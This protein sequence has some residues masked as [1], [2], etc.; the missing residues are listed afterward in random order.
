MPLR[1]RCGSTPGSPT[2]RW[3][4]ITTAPSA[5]AS[6]VR[7]RAGHGERRSRLG[8]RPCSDRA[9]G[10]ASPPDAL[11]GGAVRRSSARSGP[12]PAVSEGEA[13]LLPGLQGQVAG[14]FD[15]PLVER[16]GRLPGELG[17]QPSYPLSFRARRYLIYLALHGYTTL[18]YPFTLA[19]G[20]LRVVGT[21]AALG[22]DMGVDALVEEAVSLGFDRESARQAMTWTVAR[23]ALRTGVLHAD[24]IT[25]DHINEALEA[26]RLF[27]ERDDLRFFY[28]S[29]Q[30]Y[31]DN[32]QKL[33]VTHLHQLH[34]VLFHRGRV[35]TRPRKK[36][37][38][39]KPPLALPPRMQA[40]AQKWLAARRLT[41]AP[42]T[43]EQLE[44]AVRNFGDWLAEHYPG[45]V[46]WTE[47]T[48]DH[49]LEWIE[50]L[51]GTPSKATGKP[52]GVISRKQRISGL[53][54]LFRET[55]AWEYDD[56][57]GYALISVGDAP[58]APQR[59]PRFI[60]DHELDQ[61]MP[62]IDEITC[63]FQRAA[64][65]AV[66]WSGARRDEIRRL[67][68]D[69][70]DRYPDGTPRLRLPARK[71]YKERTV[72]LHQ[73]AADALQKVIDLRKQGR[74]RPFTD[75]RTG[76]QIRY[77]F[78]RHGKLIS[79]TYLFEDPLQKASKA[80]G[81]VGPG[82]WHGKQR[83]TV[84]AH[85]FRHT[86]PP[87]GRAA[88]RPRRR[89]TRLDL[90]S[91]TAHRRGPATPGPAHRPRRDHRPRRRPPERTTTLHVYRLSE[92]IDDFDGLTP[93]NEW[94]DSD[95]ERLAWALQ[96]VLALAEAAPTVGPPTRSPPA[97][98]EPGCHPTPATC[99]WTSPNPASSSPASTRPSPPSDRRRSP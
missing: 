4:P 45:I 62:V 6:P 65:L 85:R 51:A 80:V 47:V 70:L 82:G 69:C 28:P 11:P 67:P 81:L 25:E 36:M 42:S 24:G 74:D 26:V 73:D 5:R 58:K 98:S 30:K 79:S 15:E 12:A 86:G 44:L 96:A 21:A 2:P 77:L 54:Q 68:I 1:S 17:H 23:I 72:P 49:C 71:T 14:W 78:V 27:S 48:R 75:E 29:A 3:S 13:A 34:V 95:A 94:L 53:S 52:L 16:V 41:D 37:P 56:V 19:A 7:A 91:R 8:R 32:A 10:R 87:G 76:E 35:P 20:Q 84:S 66:R 46:S 59:V 88:A 99:A 90:R 22:I 83:G 39:R 43:T 64:L 50:Y 97:R 63:P 61:L 9:A 55:A 89:R 38:D 33:W 93:L 40:V 31:R 57:P 18:D 92:P 60:P